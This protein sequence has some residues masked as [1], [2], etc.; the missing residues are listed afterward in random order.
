MLRSLFRFVREY[1]SR[2]TV[3][4]ALALP[5]ALS[6]GFVPFR[7]S[8]TNVGA[9]LCLVALVEALAI[10]GNRASGYVATLSSAIWFDF[11]LTPP[12]ERFTISHRPDLETTI[13]I[14]VIGVIVT[15][16][17]ARSRRHRHAAGEESKF[18]AML[19]DA[20]EMSAG[21]AKAAKVT[22]FVAN[23]SSTSSGFEPAISRPISRDLRPLES[24]LGATWSTSDSTGRPTTSE[25][26][27][28]RPRSSAGSVARRSGDS[29]S[30]PRPASLYRASAASSPCRWRISSR[31][32]SMKSAPCHRRDSDRSRVGS[33][34]AR[35][36]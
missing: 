26:L 17:A 3:A 8:F 20:T 14:V 29:S 15:E 6:A 11:F 35:S 16:V 21:T 10:F 2:V 1:R 33:V 32:C 19:H 25:Y 12:Y 13:S 7:D 4:A 5:L 9:A 36:T 27:V 23:P 28:P 22:E 31:R 30:S 24:N 18:V 34:L